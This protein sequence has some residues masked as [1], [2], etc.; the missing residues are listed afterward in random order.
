MGNLIYIAGENAEKIIKDE[1]L[2]QERVRIIPC[3]AGGPKFLGISSIDKALFGEFFKDRKK[4]LSAI[5]VSIGAWRMVAN[6]QK[7]PVKAMT[8]FEH[9]YI[10]QY[11]KHNTTAKECSNVSFELLHKYVDKTAIPNILNH[12]FLRLHIIADK[13]A[14]IVSSD[15]KCLLS[16]GIGTAMA[17]NAISP[18]SINLFFKRTIFGNERDKLP[19]FESKNFEHEFIPLTEKNFYSVVLASGS[20][21]LWM[22]GIKNIDNAPAGVYRDGGMTSYHLDFP[23][24]VKKNELVLYPHFSQTIKAHWFDKNL[25]YRKHH[26]DYMSNTLVIAPSPEFI[27]KLP[28]SKIPDRHDFIT[29][30]KNYLE[31]IKV[32]EK[33]LEQCS[34]LGNELLED[35]ASGK[36]KNKI[37]L[38]GSL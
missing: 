14:K 16:A 8:Y 15:N 26:R 19:L 18:K 24:S 31:R 29:Y 3:A 35:I 38:H 34:V 25:P 1:G 27:A 12:P 23:F 2:K 4:P 17:M 7:N 21:P 5:G 33:T 22:T 11:H 6:A 10:R 36:I 9:E 30:S 28:N 20:I 32:W 13:A 37:N